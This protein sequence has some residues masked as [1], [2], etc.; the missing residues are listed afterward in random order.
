MSTATHRHF[1][2]ELSG[3][4]VKLLTMSAEA[5]Q[6]LA[7]AVMALLERDAEQA[8]KVI[9][10]DRAIDAMELEIEETVIRLLATQ[11]PMARDLRLLTAAM[12]IANDLERV[13]DHAVNIA[14][15]AER[16]LK[17]RLVP[18]EPELV[19]MARQARKMLSDA[20]DAFVR[21]DARIGRE[22]CRR[23]DMVDALHRSVFRIVLTHMMEDP[24]TIG[25]GMELVLVGRNLERVADLATNIAEDVV[26]LVEG[27][28]IKHH[29][30]DAG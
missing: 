30:E 21:G 3:L 6:A 17:E 4:K 24:H 2:D 25:A 29:A 28:T 13:G 5:Q 26:F 1:H 11:Q 27:K 10:G 14:Q 15:S 12:K 22:V 9:T 16:L 23:D 19:E 18:P 8:A 7:T 20:L